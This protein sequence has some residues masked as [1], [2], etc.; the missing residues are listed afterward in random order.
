MA[1]RRWLILGI[2]TSILCA[3]DPGRFYRPI[4]WVESSVGTW[5]VET[6][7]LRVEM[8][9]PGSLSGATS[10]IPEAMVYNRTEDEIVFERATLS[11]DRKTYDGEFFGKE[12]ADI[13]TIPAGTTR[14]V[15]I[16]FEMGAPLYESL[17]NRVEMVLSYRVGHD[18]QGTLAVHLVR[19]EGNHARRE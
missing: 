14:R 13:L 3:C 17:G 10:F 6:E 16:K 15:P 4:G 5:K 1:T 2:V 11:T 8:W 19:G 9:S 12:G 7:D 18:R